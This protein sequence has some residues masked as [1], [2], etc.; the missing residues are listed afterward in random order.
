MRKEEEKVEKEEEIEDRFFWDEPADSPLNITFTPNLPPSLST[1]ETA[2]LN[3]LIERLTSPDE[4][5]NLLL[6]ISLF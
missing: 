4:Y 3:K 1:I 6:I 5:C 2:T